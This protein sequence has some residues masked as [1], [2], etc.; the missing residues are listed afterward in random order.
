MTARHQVTRLAIT[1]LLLLGGC[2]SDGRIPV[3][4]EVMFDGQPVTD[5][6]IVMEPADAQ[7]QPVGGKIVNGRYDLK[8]KRPHCPAR[9][10]C[11]L[12]R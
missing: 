6:S 5:G 9:K 2:S 3:G 7:G 10:R 12:S 8:G 11:V 4:G 1:A